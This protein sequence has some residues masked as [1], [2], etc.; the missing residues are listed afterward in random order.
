MKIPALLFLLSLALSAC[1]FSAPTPP[2]QPLATSV[3]VERFMGT[4]Y[5]HG[6]TPTF[7]DRNAYDATE[8]YERDEDGMILTTYRFRKGSHEGNWRTIRPKGWVHDEQSNA[9]WRMRFFGLFTGPYYILHVSPDYQQT[10]VGHPG[11]ELAWIM[12]RSPIIS[13]QDYQRLRAELENRSYNL[14]EMVRVPHRPD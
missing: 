12:T 8:S 2:N 14:S 13:E 6:H 4:W 11:R 5:V 9:E 10:V 1:T 7:L 3:D